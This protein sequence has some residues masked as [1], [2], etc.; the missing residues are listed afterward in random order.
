MVY[1]W[2][3]TEKLTMPVPLPEQPGKSIGIL[4]TCSHLPDDERLAIE[5]IVSACQFPQFPH[6]LLIIQQSNDDADLGVDYLFE[7]ESPVSAQTSVSLTS[8]N[9]HIL[10]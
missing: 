1:N 2:G 6:R 3:T 8:Y 5:P 4:N 9:S 7:E 10:C